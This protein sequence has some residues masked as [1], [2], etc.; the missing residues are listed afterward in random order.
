[1]LLEKYL[2]QSLQISCHWLELGMAFTTG[3]LF[4]SASEAPFVSSCR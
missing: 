3:K 2:I 4:F 1:M